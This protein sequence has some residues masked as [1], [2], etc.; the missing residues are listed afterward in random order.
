MD[1]EKFSFLKKGNKGK[2][3]GERGEEGEKGIDANAY[4]S[5]KEEENNIEMIENNILYNINDI[6]YIYMI[7]KSIKITK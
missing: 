3:R 7:Y 2:Q 6:I 5:V 1:L 4:N